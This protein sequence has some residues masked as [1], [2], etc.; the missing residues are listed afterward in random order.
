MKKLF[1]ISAIA[2]LILLAGFLVFFF[3]FVPSMVEKSLNPIIAKSPYRVSERAQNLHDQ[4][5]VADLHADALLWNRN[6]LEDSP[7]AQVDVPKLVRGNVALQAFT[8]VTKTPRGLNIETNTDETDNIFWLALA[9]RQPLENLSSLTKR[10]VFQANKLHEYA[11]ESNGKLV[12]IQTKTDLRNFL[13][14][15]KTD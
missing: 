6:L 9:Q 12:V 4:L 11:A 1:K 15:R 3:G 7:I 10:A 13:E 14:R 8:V 5:I 2:L